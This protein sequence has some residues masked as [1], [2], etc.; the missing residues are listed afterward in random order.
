MEF[1]FGNYSL[2][3]NVKDFKVL[4]KSVSQ[5]KQHT[6]ISDQQV[7]VPDS[8]LHTALDHALWN[9][10]WHYVSTPKVPHSQSF[11]RPLTGISYVQGNI[12][13]TKYRTLCAHVF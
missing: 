12:Y 5:G 11:G 10:E 13:L 7:A 9:A 6:L 3:F 8:K 4:L 1:I 2:I